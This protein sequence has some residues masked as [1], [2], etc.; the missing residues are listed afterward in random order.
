MSFLRQ[1]RFAV[2]GVLFILSTI[3]ATS[4]LMIP[5]ALTPVASAD[6]CPQDSYPQYNIIYC[7]LTGPTDA[8]YISSLQGYYN[9]NSDGHGNTD[10]QAVLNWAGATPSIINGMNTSNTMI[11]TAYNDGSITVNGQTVGTNALVAGRWNP[12]TGGFTHIEGN[13]WDRAATTYF[14]YNQS[15]VQVLVHLNSYDQ[16][17][18]AIM[19]ECG[20]V[21]KFTPMPP[22]SISCSSLTDSEV[23]STLQYK[24]TAKASAQNMSITSYTFNFGDGNTQQVVTSDTTANASNTYSQYD[25]TYSADVTV[26]GSVPSITSSCAVQFTTPPKPVTP[27]LA[28]VVLTPAQVD[29]NVNEY[30]FTANATANDVT[31]VNYIFDYGDGS[32]P[33]TIPTNSLS[34]TTLPHTFASGTWTTNVTVNG[35]ENNGDSQTAISTSCQAQVTV[36]PTTPP[37]LVNTGP[38]NFIGIAGAAAIVGGLSHYFISRRQLT[39]DK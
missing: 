22:K 17:D 14:A 20:N 35:T 23:D 32:T 5:S 24:F 21:L 26:A 7:G 25:H 18:F 29:N 38:G 27:S 9:S 3:T 13:V 11:G 39:S 19:I 31:I 1:C 37:V 4:L 33:T 28:C 10:I 36:P 30:T 2:L 12:G 34:A 15:Q 6:S 16:A 8:N